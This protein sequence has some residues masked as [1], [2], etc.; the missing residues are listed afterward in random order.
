MEVGDQ[1]K[2]I[3]SIWNNS[4]GNENTFPGANPVSLERKNFE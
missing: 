4:K 3:N 1:Y 2:N